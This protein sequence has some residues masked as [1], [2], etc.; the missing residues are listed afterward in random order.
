MNR[1]GQIAINYCLNQVQHVYG[2]GK[3]LKAFLPYHQ[4]WER[5]II[6]LL[7]S[8]TNVGSKYFLC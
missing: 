5:A 6:K 2:E 7:I 4:K 1:F 3:D 8:Y